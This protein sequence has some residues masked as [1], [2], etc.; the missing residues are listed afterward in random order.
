MLFVKV[1]FP[2]VS[3]VMIFTL[4]AF[5]WDKLRK[6]SLVDDHPCDKIMYFL[7]YKTIDLQ[8]DVAGCVNF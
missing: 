8:L 6:V 4:V 7:L 3:Q 1:P 5:H 2:R